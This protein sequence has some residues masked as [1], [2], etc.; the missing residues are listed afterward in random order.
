MVDKHYFVNTARAAAIAYR[1]GRIEELKGLI[2]EWTVN[3][4]YHHPVMYG[5]AVFMDHTY[6]GLLALDAGD[7]EMAKLELLKSGK[8]PT[9]PVLKSFGP[10]LSLGKRLL[11]AGETE[12]VLQFLEFCKD[13]WLLPLRILH[14]P[15]WKREIEAGKIPNFG[16]NLFYLMDM[17][18][19]ED[20]K[21][22]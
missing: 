13:F 16:G 4:I 10:N 7:I 21:A 14:L 6:R 15:R 12:V 11:E 22:G 19:L 2:E 5:E 17:P 20:D 1:E 8:A 3:T 9:S 18:E